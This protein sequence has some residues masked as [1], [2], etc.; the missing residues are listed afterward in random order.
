MP[1]RLLALASVVVLLFAMP[2]DGAAQQRPPARFF[3]A[4]VGDTTFTFP[5]PSDPWVRAGMEGLAIDPGRRDSL[6]ARFRVAQVS[7]GEA[8][9]VI[10]GQ[11]TTVVP[12]HVA[13]LPMPHP[14]WYRR[15]HFWLGLLAGAGVGAGVVAATR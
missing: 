14:P 6:V 11:M 1:P 12:G 15:T 4:T 8:V 2:A 3:I 7:W 13:M 10:T 9:A 5:V